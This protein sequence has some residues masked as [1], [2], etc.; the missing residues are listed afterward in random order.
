M[1]IFFPQ[2][3]YLKDHKE[4]SMQNQKEFVSTDM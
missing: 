2:F 1:Q 4:A 3:H